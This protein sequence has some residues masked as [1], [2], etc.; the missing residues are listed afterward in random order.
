M[1]RMVLTDVELS[2][3]PGGASAVMFSDRVKSVTLSL[4]AS[5]HEITAF[6]E[7]AIRRLPGLKDSSLSVEFYGDEAAGNVNATLWAVY[8]ATVPSS[9]SVKRDDAAVSATNPAYEGNI[10]LESFDVGPGELNSPH[11]V[12]VSFQGD[13]DVT[14]RTT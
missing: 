11:M 8:N 6:G 3:T 13:G 7:G 2:I 12:S 5:L 4:N 14:R 9:Y 1:A 10:W